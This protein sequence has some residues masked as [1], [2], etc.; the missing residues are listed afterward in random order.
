MKKIEQADKFLQE[1]MEST[2][3]NTILNELKPWFSP[4][5]KIEDSLK[6]MA[7]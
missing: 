6:K 7:L 4:M 3:I 5:Q 1:K 2:G